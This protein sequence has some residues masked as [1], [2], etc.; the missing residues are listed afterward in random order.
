ME[1]GTGLRNQATELA[2]PIAARSG[3]AGGQPSGSPGR[4]LE[5]VS[6]AQIA[7]VVLFAALIG[8]GAGFGGHFLFATPAPSPAT[9]PFSAALHG[10]A[11][12]PAGTRPAP[13]I[14]TLRDQSGHRFSL[15]SVR[16]RTVAMVFFDSHCKQQCPLAGRALAASM[17]TLPPAQRP[18][19]VVVSVN[20]LD[21][22]ASTRLAVSAWGLAGLAPWHW[23]MGTHAE[24]GAVWK[25]YHIFVQPEKGD[26][27]HTDALYLVDRHGDERSG[28]LYPYLPG[29][30]AHDLRVLAPPGAGRRS[31]HV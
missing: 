18:V 26:I 17:R 16:G 3:Q 25:A 24:L 31:G 7:V 27:S 11:T 22:P 5:R 13:P 19:L 10:E 1:A 14:T 30:V 23:L 29:F 8:A 4:K 28:Y 20:P 15:E 12:W 21:S 6:A 9:T 2:E